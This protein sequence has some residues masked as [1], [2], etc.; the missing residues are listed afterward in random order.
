M[1]RPVE[2]CS[3]AAYRLHNE[4]MSDKV[5]IIADTRHTQRWSE[6]GVDPLLCNG[7]LA[8]F[9]KC[10]TTLEGLSL[11]AHERTP[12]VPRN[13]EDS[14]TVDLAD[15]LGAIAEDLHLTRCAQVCF[16][17]T[18]EDQTEQQDQGTID[19]VLG[20]PDLKQEKDSLEEADR[21]AD[22]LEQKP[23]LGHPEPE[24]EHLASW[25]RPR[26][27]IRRL[28]RNLRHLPREALVQMLHAARAPQDYINAAKTFHNTKSRS[29]THKGSPPGP[30]TLN[31]DV[32]DDVFE[33]VDSV[34]V[35]YSILNAICM[36]T[37]YDQAWI[38][39]E[40]EVHGSPSSHACLQ[41]FVHG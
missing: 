6:R 14:E 11:W 29:Q 22:L 4:N 24:K 1:E 26:A 38:V 31:H 5:M 8:F 41:A 13:V 20:G 15:V 7:D 3:L 17:G 34:G 9:S 16:A 33:I 18:E 40:S 39:R 35:R 27:A 25:L 2:M 10:I 32:R 23:L 19:E 37:T 30:H 36:G 28:H 12:G 21:E